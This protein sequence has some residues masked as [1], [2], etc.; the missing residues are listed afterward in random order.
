MVIRKLRS[1]K[2]EVD[3]IFNSH[4]TSQISNYPTKISKNVISSVVRRVMW[5]P[6]VPLI[7]EFGLMNALIFSQD[8]AVTHAF[9]AVKLRWWIFHVNNYESH[10][11][12]R[13]YN[14]AIIIDEFSMRG[15]SCDFIELNTLNCNKIDIINNDI[16]NDDIVSDDIINDYNTNDDIADEVIINNELFNA[17]KT[18]SQLTSLEPLSP[19][20]SFT[21]NKPNTPSVTFGKD[22]SKQ[23]ITFVNLNESNLNNICVPLNCTTDMSGCTIGNDE[24]RIDIMPVNGEAVNIDLSQEIEIFKLV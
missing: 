16:I 19:I 23:D 21:A 1:V 7:A 13:S 6:V 4:P 17:P 18:L 11:P 3:D 2:K 8:I 24:G 20:N 9:Q 5:Y 12:H 15:K 22:D 14:K 10:Y